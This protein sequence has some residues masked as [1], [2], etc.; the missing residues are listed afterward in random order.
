LNA[1]AKRNEK[2][3]RERKERREKKGSRG[4]YYVEIE[5]RV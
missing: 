1:I 2:E 4:N 3:Q 5:E